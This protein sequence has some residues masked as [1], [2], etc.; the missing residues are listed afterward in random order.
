[1]AG[2]QQRLFYQRRCHARACGALFFI[3]RPCYRGQR[4]CSEACRQVSRQQ[5][6]RAANR[7]HQQTPE[8]RLDHIDR[9]REYRRRRSARVTDQGSAAGSSCGSI[10]A[11]D[12]ITRRAVRLAGRGVLCIVCGCRGRFIQLNRE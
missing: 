3:C 1:M 4:Y 8:G 6:R 11:V 9:Q 7:R 10:A 5:Q 12:P 2:V